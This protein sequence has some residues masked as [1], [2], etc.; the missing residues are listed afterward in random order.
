MSELEPCSGA[1]TLGAFLEGRLRGREL[2]EVVAHL[3]ACAECRDLVGEAARFEREVPAPAGALVRFPWWRP[4]AAAAAALL[5]LSL[6]G[7]WFLSRDPLTPVR[8]AASAAPLRAIRARLAGFDHAG[9]PGTERGPEVE[10]SA[11]LRLRA[12]ATEVVEHLEQSKE[13]EEL[14]AAGV[15]ALIARRA[16]ATAKLREAARLAPEEPHYWNDLAAALYTRAVTEEDP[17]ELAE[18]LAAADRALRLA[19]ADADA[20]FNRALILEALG[21]YQHATTAWQAYL[22][23]DPAS[24][25]AVEARARVQ[26]LEKLSRGDE[27]RKAVEILTTPQGDDGALG[28]TV[29]AFPEEARRYAEAATL[30][31]WAR[32]FET[33]AWPEAEA[34]LDDARTIGHLLT[35]RNGEQLVAD[36]VAAID[37]CPDDACRSR[38]AHAHRRY[39]DARRSYG[40]GDVSAAL[41]EL[42]ASVQLFRKLKTP[43]ALA[44][45]YY[46]ICCLEDQS[47]RSVAGAV[48]RLVPQ[49]PERYPAL[50]AQLFWATGTYC[51]RVGRNAEA[52]EAYRQAL[53]LFERLGET[54]NAN[55]MQSA[56]SAPQSLLGQPAGAWRLRAAALAGFSRAGANA[57]L[58]RALELAGRMEAV[59]GRWSA[60]SALFALA[61]EEPFRVNPRTHVSAMLWGALAAH[62][63]GFT[64][65]AQHQLAA[66]RRFV[67]SI[68]DPSL[69][70]TALDD[71]TFAEAS[72]LRH[73]DPAR[74]AAIFDRYL[75]IAD[76]RGRTFLLPEAYLERARAARG[77][78]KKRV[79]ERFYRAAL[80][81]AEE[82]RQD[83]LAVGIVQAYF[84]TASTAANELT[85]VLESEGRTTEAF[86][87]MDAGRG[88]ALLATL[89]QVGRIGAKPPRAE[90][91]R[92]AVLASARVVSYLQ[93]DERL[94]IFTIGRAQGTRVT[95]VAVRAAEVRRAIADF[96]AA[97]GRDDDIA[98]GALADQLHAW[99][100]APLAGS[101]GGVKTLVVIPDPAMESLPFAALREGPG[102][103]WLVERFAVVV[104]PS[105]MVFVHSARNAV[106]ATGGVMSYGNPAFVRSRFAALG[107]LPAAERE[108]REVANHYPE[109]AAVTGADATASRFLRELPFAR[110]VHLAAH[111]V[112]SRHE[113][114]RSM[115]LLAPDAATPTGVVYAGD[116]AAATC[117]AQVVVLAGCRTAAAAETRYDIHSLGL[118]FLAAGARNVVGTLWNVDD[119]EAERFS[120]RL[121]ANL[122]AGVQPAEAV[123]RAQCDLLATRPL[124]VWSAFTLAGSGI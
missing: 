92:G 106:T 32:E 118:A 79:A 66:A 81:M 39:D 18:A 58:Q 85:D 54:L 74:A 112:A 97:I 72:V 76:R 110:V 27:R 28:P 52:F 6:G 69:R 119:E 64:Q 19:P 7:W 49:V 38:F 44:A 104:A 43:M 105:A 73:H 53:A 91:I 123:R 20:L 40:A 55:R 65:G 3:E 50:R 2:A 121:H 78:R 60:A 94:L 122:S 57:E 86:A 51:G 37:R 89:A 48:A 114:M 111:A 36:A 4:A 93:L 67:W 35:T 22:H 25:W 68:H 90:E 82:R 9:A 23:V 120:G 13:V 5:A 101:L 46:V 96:R 47:S 8:T 33:G 56:A 26:A 10:S 29:A 71:L 115:L 62:R 70:A 63:E 12:A 16:G 30:G 75:A 80:A 15:A 103:P 84:A 107:P 17:Q 100:I 61:T 113:P 116:V 102:G 117:K 124:R 45:E 95:R 31:R 14:H 109:A 11:T 59:D 88:R 34:A 108:A 1:E 99:L 77:V 87:T 21:L 98:A 24:P 83:S 42:L 41:P